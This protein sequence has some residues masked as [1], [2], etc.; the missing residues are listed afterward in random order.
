MPIYEFMR[1]TRR[2][3]LRSRHSRANSQFSHRARG[4]SIVETIVAIA[5]LSVVVVA[6]LTL[7]QRGLNSSIYARDQVTAF[8]LA[9]EAIEY[10]RNIRDNNNLI[11]RSRTGDWL[12]GLETC[13]KST[14]C[15]IDV[16]AG[17]IIDCDDKGNPKLR[18]CQLTFDPSTGIY[19]DHRDNGN[20]DPVGNLQDSIFTRKLIITPIA[21]GSDLNGEADL[22]VTVSWQTGLLQKSVVINERIF[23]W[24]PA[25]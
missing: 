13:K 7:A 24:Y 22:A 4:F 12:K 15:G 16:N 3:I 1:M 5:I 20:G 17:R 25:Q 23:N 6:P 11:G 10:V 9:Q 14:E 18:P 21:V 8:Y 19:G 2:P